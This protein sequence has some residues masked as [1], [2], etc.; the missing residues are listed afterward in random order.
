LAL[1]VPAR[2]P[3]QNLEAAAVDRIVQDGLKAWQVPGAALVLVQ[4]DRVVYLKG[5]GVCERGGAKPVTPDTLFAIASLTKAFTTTA[6]ALLVDEGKLAWDDPV[7]KHVPFFRLADPLADRNVTLRDLV[8]HRTGVG[9]HD[10]LWLHAPWSQEETIRRV[11]FLRPSHSFRAAYE[12]NNIMYMTAGLAVASASQGSWPDFVRRRLLVPLGMTGAV[13]TRS[14]VLARPDH[15]SPHH[16]EAGG[17]VRVLPW[18]DDDRQI[19]ASGSIK[20]SARDLGNWLRFQ[21]GDGTFAGKRLL[22][23]RNLAETHRPQMVIRLEGALKAAHPETTQMSYGLG[24]IIQ[25]YR[26]RLIYSH[27]GGL[28][29][30][31]ARI[32]LVPAAGWGMALLMNADAGDDR[33][34]MHLAVTN[35]LLDHLLRLPTRDWTGHYAGLAKKWQEEA[36]SLQVARLAKR[37][38]GT[39]PAR[40]LQAYAGTYSE[41]AYGEATITRE[42][43]GLVLRWSSFRLRLEHYHFE[44]FTARGEGLVAGRPAVFR[45]GADGEVAGMR[46]LGRNF[47]RKRTAARGQNGRP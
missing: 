10:L 40:E 2:A 25:D 9:R 37:H 31:R 20:A 41:P 21:L 6:L 17:K 47:T 35:Q 4:G 30:F 15:A 42:D 36:R 22:S 29:G 28:P 12:Y 18:Y 7:R 39:R 8:C 44:T 14:A 43:G 1:V 45:L 38:Q 19:R 46:F 23:A 3:A 16:A 24:W 33:A 32:V 5:H 11:A 34:S 26:G 27:T 13:F